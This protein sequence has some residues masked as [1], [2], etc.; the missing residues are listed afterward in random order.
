MLF[1]GRLQVSRRYLNLLEVP[2]KCKLLEAGT[3]G[4]LRSQLDSPVSQ[5]R[6]PA[7]LVPCL[8]LGPHWNH[9]FWPF[10]ILCHL[11]PIFSFSCKQ[12]WSQ[13]IPEMR[14]VTICV[15]HLVM[16]PHF[17]QNLFG[18]LYQTLKKS[19][20]ICCSWGVYRPKDDLGFNLSLNL[21]SVKWGICAVYHVPWST[22]ALWRSRD[23]DTVEIWK[24]HW[25]TYQRTN[26]LT[27][28]R[29]SFWRCLRM[30]IISKFLGF[31]WQHS[32]MGSSVISWKYKLI[33]I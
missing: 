7:C 9:T 4:T 27:S 17:T 31:S 16:I 24:C 2:I 6:H 18:K 25:P 32:V 20:L 28:D 13:V 5:P 23:T 1:V 19:L 33:A 11:S 29:G 15:K 14:K 26:I 22:D 10:S 30:I 8:Y 21:T 12:T 3:G